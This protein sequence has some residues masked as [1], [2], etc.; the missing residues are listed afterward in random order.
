MKTTSLKWMLTHI[1]PPFEK[2]NIMFINKCQFHPERSVIRRVIYINLGKLLYFL[3][4]NYPPV[5]KHRKRKIPILNRKIHLQI[6]DFPLLCVDFLNDQGMYLARWTPYN[7][8]PNQGDQPVGS[9][10]AMKF[11]QMYHVIKFYRTFC[12]SHSTKT[13]TLLRPLYFSATKT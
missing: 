6:V 1:I 3:N 11:A 13:N 9:L 5:N 12:K 7:R 10:V 4:L 2:E 8:H